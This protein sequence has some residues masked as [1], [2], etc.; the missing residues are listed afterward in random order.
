MKNI[1]KKIKKIGGIMG[2]FL[3][4]ICSKVFA[5]VPMSMLSKDVDSPLY[6][7]PERSLIIYKIFDFGII[8]L[9]PFILLLGLFIYYKKKDKEKYAERITIIKRLLIIIS[10]LLLIIIGLNL[11]YLKYL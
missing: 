8:L 5:E 7:V 1:F 3:F 10:V 4:S 9:I 2:V 6:G 11:L